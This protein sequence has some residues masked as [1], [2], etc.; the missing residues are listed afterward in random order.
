MD[1]DDNQDKRMTCTVNLLVTKQLFPHQI[2]I[3]IGC[4]ISYVRRI[5]PLAQIYS[6]HFGSECRKV[7]PFT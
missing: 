6:F 1:G 2:V 4:F 5:F 7:F 3:V